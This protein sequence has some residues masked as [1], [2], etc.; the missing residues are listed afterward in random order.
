MPLP[1]A[2]HPTNDPAWKSERRPI[3]LLRRRLSLYL[4]R[5]VMVLRDFLGQ[6]AIRMLHLSRLPERSPCRPEIFFLLL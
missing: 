5:R 6:H 4:P 3:L 2:N 1:E